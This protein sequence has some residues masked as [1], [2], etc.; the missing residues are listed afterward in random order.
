MLEKFLREPSW[1]RDEDVLE[2]LTFV[3][4]TETAQNGAV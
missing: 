1:L 4:Q 2:L 3:F